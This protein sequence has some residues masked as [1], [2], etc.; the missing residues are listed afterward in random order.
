MHGLPTMVA[1]K[2]SEKGCPSV[3]PTRGKYSS[4]WQQQ[5]GALPLGKRSEKGCPSVLPTRGKYSG[6]WQQQSGAL[7]LRHLQVLDQSQ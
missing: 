3:L 1:W 2:W 5:S 7:P 6:T 4:T